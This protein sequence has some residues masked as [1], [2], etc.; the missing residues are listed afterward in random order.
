[1]AVVAIAVA[2]TRDAKESNL[3]LMLL[4]VN[5]AELRPLTGPIWRTITRIVWL[6]D[7]SGLAIIGAG[8]DPQEGAQLWFVDFPSGESRRVTN[9]VSLYDN[10]LS[11]GTDA[12]RLLLVQQKQINNL[13]LAPANDLGKARQLTFTGPNITFG[14]FAFDWLSQNRIVYAAPTG[15]NI[16]LMT[17]NPEG[18]EVKEIT[19][20]GSD[21]EPSTPADGRFIAFQS[22]RG[23]SDQIWRIDPDGGNAKQ[24]TSCGQN[25]QPSVSP[26]GR[27][28]VFVS[29]CNGSNALWRVSSDGDQ[30]K[31]LTERA[32]NWPWFSPDGKW[33]AGIYRLD[34]GKTNIAIFSTEGGTP[35]K[36][37]DL[38]PRANTNYRIRWTPDS[39]AVVYRGWSQGLWRQNLSGGPPQRIAGI[40]EE[41]IGSFGWSHDG[42]LFG[43]GRVAQ[44]RDVVMI[45]NSN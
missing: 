32:V 21:A 26:D 17:M 19:P 10:G 3:S 42:T 30:A 20:P 15:Q 4:A 45:T 36:L 27:W 37:L 44:F 6:R 13:W 35:V 28:V 43:F 7:G 41:K 38:A 31:R 18:K 1:L 5:G 11:V 39:S 33:I 8:A 2:A 23:G 12:N 14:T 34:S 40:P 24:L 25:Y 29:D 22:S 9:E 16:S